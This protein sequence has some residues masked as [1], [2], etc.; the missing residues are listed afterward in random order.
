MDNPNKAFNSSSVLLEGAAVLDRNGD[1][2]G[3]IESAIIDRASGALSH[4]VMSVKRFGF[5]ATR[6]LLPWNRLDYDRRTVAYRVDLT[7]EQL[8]ATSLPEEPFGMGL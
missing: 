5:V 7:R 8:Q 1:Q 2:I 3:S 6:Y 4:V